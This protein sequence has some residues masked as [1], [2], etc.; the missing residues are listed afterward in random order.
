MPTGIQVVGN[1]GAV[2]IDSETAALTLKAKGTATVTNAYTGTTITFSGATSPLL[3]FKSTNLVAVTDFTITA[4]VATA[5]LQASAAGSTVDWYAFDKPT[6]VAGNGGIQFFDASGNLT[7]DSEASPLIVQSV[8]Q[9]TDATIY[10][11]PS[12]SSPAA[13]ASVYAACLA[14]ARSGIDGDMLSFT[15]WFMDGVSTTSTGATAGRI[16]VHAASAGIT[17]QMTQSTGGKLI[18]VDV[19]LIP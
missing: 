14:T 1:H 18:L 7:F 8:T 2:I 15:R 9:V 12:T 4:G 6:Y 10:S 17:P 16:M 13:P 5:K 11:W 3:C 19:S